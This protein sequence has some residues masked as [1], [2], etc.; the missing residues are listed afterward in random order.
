MG[1]L[2]TGKWFFEE[3]GKE[4]EQ[5]FTSPTPTFVLCHC[6]NSMSVVKIFFLSRFLSHH[7]LT[8]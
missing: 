3:L 1:V 5:D 6:I 8:M 7:L 2:V 4:A